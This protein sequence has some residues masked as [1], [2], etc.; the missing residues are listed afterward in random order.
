MSISTHEDGRIG[1]RAYWFMFRVNLAI[2]VALLGAGF[3]AVAGGAFVLGILLLLAIAPVGI[4][5][6]VVMM[7]R[8]R[9]IGWPAALPWIFFGAGM[10]A[11]FG[12]YS[13]ILGVPASAQ[14]PIVGLSFLVS[15]ADFAFMVVIGW[16]R[17]TSERTNYNAIFGPDE[18]D[19]RM[20]A[21]VRV[22][23]P[24]Y[25]GETDERDEDSDARW[26]AAIQNALAARAGA[27]AEA[28]QPP[29]LPRSAGFG[30]KP[31]C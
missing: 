14:V 9:D 7:R 8:C 30:R 13:Q 25:R 28:P 10:L 22:A 19:A 1:R 6:R 12:T 4:Y 15:L 27:S 20:A 24:A 5:F 26:D 3:M 2:V 18:R 11:S 21:P 31:V 23:R 17:G 16:I 29:V